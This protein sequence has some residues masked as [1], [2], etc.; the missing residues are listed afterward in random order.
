MVPGGL[1]NDH[2]C[3]ALAQNTSA[4][5]H[6]L[7]TCPLLPSP[8]MMENNQMPCQLF[9]SQITFLINKGHVITDNEGHSTILKFYKRRHSGGCAAL[10]SPT[11]HPN[12]G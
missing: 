4:T 10:A 7:C 2:V 5:H 8:A 9:L 12:E 11:C 3:D 1:G 6:F